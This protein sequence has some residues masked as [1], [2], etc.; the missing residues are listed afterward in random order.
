MELLIMKLEKVNL[1]TLKIIK[2]SLFRKLKKFIRSGLKI[3]TI[4]SRS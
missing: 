3:I 2:K 1:I 4:D